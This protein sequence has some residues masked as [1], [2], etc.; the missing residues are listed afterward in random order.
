MLSV[1]A[2]NEI[3]S[4]SGTLKNECP[5]NQGTPE[6]FIEKCHMVKKEPEV[7][8]LKNFHVF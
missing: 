4:G 7:C 6:H 8:E 1:Q 3:N 5:G 2:R